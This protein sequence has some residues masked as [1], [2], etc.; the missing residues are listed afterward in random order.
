MKLLAQAYLIFR[1]DIAMSN[2][3]SADSHKMKALTDLGMQ[4]VGCLTKSEIEALE[5]L[6]PDEKKALVRAQQ[7]LPRDSATPANV[8]GGKIF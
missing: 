6:T 4:G 5:K 1:K 7:L 3:P 8:C 2:E